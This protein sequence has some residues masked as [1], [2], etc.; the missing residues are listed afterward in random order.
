MIDKVTIYGERCSGTNYLEELIKTNFDVTI[1]W[2]YG[3]KHFFGFNDLSNSDNTLFIG[4]I[5]NPYD[6]L[7]SLYREQHHLPKNFRRNIKNFLNNEFYSL[8]INNNE[9]MQDRNI[10]SKERYK[11][12][13]EMRYTK[14]KFLVEDMPL[15]VK[16]YILIKYEDLLNNFDI[17]INEIKSKGLIFKNNIIEVQN[18]YYYKN[19][20]KKKFIKNKKVN[21]ISKK[22]ILD[23]LNLDYEKKILNYNI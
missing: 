10:Y 12:I 9:I 16:N 13:F 23:K 18:I 2:E 17:T 7:N 22:E 5:R 11:N 6:W 8:D 3:W 19:N 4:L 21:N 15:L 14:I 1:T 20:K